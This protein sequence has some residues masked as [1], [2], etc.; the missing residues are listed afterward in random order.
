MKKYLL[1]LFL[2]LQFGGNAQSVNDYQYVIVP[3]KFGIFNENDAYRLNTVTKFMLQKYGFK[4]FLSTDSIPDE[5]VNNTCKRLY[6]ELVKNGNAFTTKLKVVLKDCRDQVVY[7][8]AVGVSKE[9]TYHVAYNQALRE[10]FKS[11]DNLKYKY[12]GN[13]DLSS[14]TSVVKPKVSE[15]SS[16]EIWYAQ[17]IQNGFQVVN[18]EPKVVLKLYKTSVDTVFIGVKDTI[19]GVVLQREN[20]WF[21]EY[22]K[23]EV[24]V[25]EI[26]KLK[27]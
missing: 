8:T 10:A 14:E 13:N 23:N 19:Q 2:V 3:I 21:F 26:L 7:E 6:V 25:S 15:V 22:Y 1:L 4:S 12:N 20:Q 5:L 16:G 24:L 17:P 27:F 9:K 18:S 11:F